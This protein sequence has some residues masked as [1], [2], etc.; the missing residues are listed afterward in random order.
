MTSPP[1]KGG[2]GGVDKDQSCAV[3]PRRAHHAALLFYCSTLYFLRRSRGCPAEPTT[4][5]YCST[6]LLS[7]F[8]GEAA[9]APRA[10]T[11]PESRAVEQ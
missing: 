1:C 8:C 4:Q 10:A 3:M 7:I 11:P 9:G 5:L 6:A 2:V